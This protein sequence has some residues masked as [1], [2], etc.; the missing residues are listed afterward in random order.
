MT[1]NCPATEIQYQGKCPVKT[2]PAWLARAESGCIYQDLK[3]EVSPFSIC[4]RLKLTNTQIKKDYKRGVK[5]LTESAKFYHL[6]LQSFTAPLKTCSNC[7]ISGD[8]CINKVR[9]NKRKT[10]A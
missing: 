1:N 3:G 4:S 6:S 8:D 10:F 5:L 9:C 7:G 2:C